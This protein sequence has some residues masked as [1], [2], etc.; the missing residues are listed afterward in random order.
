[1][2]ICGS[3]TNKANAVEP[4]PNISGAP[5]YEVTVDKNNPSTELDQFMAYVVKSL[6]KIRYGDQIAS[7]FLIRLFK[8]QE[9]FFCMMTCEHV[10]K[11]EMFRQRKTISFYYDSVN[12]KTIGITLDPNERFIQDFRSLN[13]MD[14]NIDINIDATVIQILPKDSIPKEFTF[15]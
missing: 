13:E 6:C 1:M 12:F 15:L 3:S 9:E 14:S 10:I 5:H 4:L 8:G 7:G 2:G 11:R